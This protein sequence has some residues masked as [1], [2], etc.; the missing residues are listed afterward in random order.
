MT[1]YVDDMHEF[2]MG[3]LRRMKC[4][5]MIADTREELFEMARKLGL[6]LKWVQKAG[7]YQEHFDV[8]KGKRDM[9]LKLGAIPI[10]MRQCSAM[11]VRRKVEGKLGPHYEAEMWHRRRLIHNPKPVADAPI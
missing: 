8:A 9:A 1:V 3:Q 4:S 2:Q 6:Q 5:H 11:C 7:T 10:T